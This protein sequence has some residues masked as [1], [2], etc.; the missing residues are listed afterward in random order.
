M[1]TPEGGELWGKSETLFAATD[2]EVVCF[3]NAVEEA[4]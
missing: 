4:G 3:N 2:K 1:V